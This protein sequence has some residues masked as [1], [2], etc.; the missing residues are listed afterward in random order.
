MIGDGV[1]LLVPLLPDQIVNLS[2]V[3]KSVFS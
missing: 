2:V 1:L 3:P